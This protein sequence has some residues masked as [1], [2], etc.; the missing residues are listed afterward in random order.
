MTLNSLEKGEIAKP[1]YYYYIYCRHF[2]IASYKYLNYFSINLTNYKDKIIFLQ[3]YYGLKKL[4]ELDK[5][6]KL[7]AGCI[8]DYL[9]RNRNKYIE[10]IIDN[11]I[12]KLK[13]K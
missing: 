1:Y 12:N 5:K 8:T 10:N 13:K 9:S 11:E 7:Y 3:L 2:N 4:K 6:L